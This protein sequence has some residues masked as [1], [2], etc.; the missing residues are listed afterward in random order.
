MSG[1]PF[2]IDSY[3]IQTDYEKQRSFMLLN[4]QRQ[5][6]STAAMIIYADDA[7]IITSDI[8]YLYDNMDTDQTDD[9]DKNRI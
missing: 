8:I 2:A 9:S 4:K 1:V 7:D 3:Q 5:R 6:E